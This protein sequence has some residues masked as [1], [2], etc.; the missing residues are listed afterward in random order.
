MR[1]RHFTMINNP[2][3]DETPS[4]FLRACRREPVDTTPVWLMRQAGRYMP[5]YR[6]LREKYPILTMVKTPELAVEVTMQPMRA[7]DLDA[8][9]IFADILPPLEG[10]GLRLEFAQG[11]GP[12]I[13]NPI[14]TPA[15]VAALRTPPAAEA[16]SFTLEAIRLTRRELDPAR[17]LIGF[18]GA[19]FTL[20]CYALEGGSS[21]YYTQAK[22]FMYHEPAAWH[23][24]MGKLATVVGDYLAE[25]VRAGAQAVQLFDSWV[26]A[27]SPTDYREQVLPY[28]RQALAAVGNGRCAVPPPAPP[29]AGGSGEVG[30]GRC[31]VPYVPVI[32]FSTGTAGMLE[33][34]R[35]AGGDVIGVDWTI[36]L[37]DAWARLGDG[38]AIQGN[39]DPVALLAPRDVLLCRAADVL[40][41]AAGRPGHIFNLGHGVLPQTPVENVAALVDFVHEQ[42]VRNQP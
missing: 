1:F 5:E 27:L 21:R 25:Q 13:H 35:E 15:D 2:P 30:N 9:I 3:G 29:Q 41:R 26:G 34:I 11:E 4:R 42:G 12:V 40:C 38:V 20:A 6:R 17:A 36:H 10:M 39:L 24:L 14:R 7:F 16:L 28:S 23:E 18:S 33:L 31:A 32:H 19:P 8:A 22:S 37:D